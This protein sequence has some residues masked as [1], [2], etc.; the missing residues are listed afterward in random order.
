MLTSG[1]PLKYA[2]LESLS[3]G[4]LAWIV[5]FSLFEFGRWSITMHVQWT[6]VATATVVENFPDRLEKFPALVQKFP[7]PMS[8]EFGDKMPALLDYLGCLNLK[9]PHY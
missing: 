7:A 3:R 8:R 5:G 9:R 6:S 2:V 1:L 4:G